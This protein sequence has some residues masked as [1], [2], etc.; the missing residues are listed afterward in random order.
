MR[1]HELPRWGRIDILFRRYC[2]HIQPTPTH[3]NVPIN[4]HRLVLHSATPSVAVVA[5]I[6]AVPSP[7]AHAQ[8][9]LF[10]TGVWVQEVPTT[11]L[12][13]RSARLRHRGYEA[14]AQQRRNRDKDKDVV[15][16]DKDKAVKGPLFAILSISEQ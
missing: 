1:A 13:R 6:L 5:L 7:P 9:S 3:A 10:S 11:Q 15:A 14:D 8:G 16:K 2:I 12:P 4:L